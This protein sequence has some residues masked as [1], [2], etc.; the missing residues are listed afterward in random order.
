MVVTV[1]GVV[2]VGGGL[3]A[4]ALV[5]QFRVSREEPWQS[6]PPL[7]GAGSVQVLSLYWVPPP[8]D[9]LHGL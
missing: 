7:A 5:L 4:Q 3:V 2:V 1:G 8:Q 6:R 9:L